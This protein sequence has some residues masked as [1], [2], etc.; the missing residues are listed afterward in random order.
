MY[1]SK[2]SQQKIIHD[3]QQKFSNIIKC[4]SRGPRLETCVDAHYSLHDQEKQ[5]LDNKSAILASPW[6]SLLM[7]I[8]QDGHVAMHRESL[9]HCIAVS[10]VRL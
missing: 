8:L 6:Q 2:L 10:S 7:S 9:V 1:H 4:S 3:N 5:R